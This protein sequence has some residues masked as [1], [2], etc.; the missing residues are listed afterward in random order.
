MHEQTW[1]QWFRMNIDKFLLL[2]AF[3]GIMTFVLHVS[4][5]SMDKELI[6]WGR[7]LGSGAFASFLTM[8]TGSVLRQTGTMP[9]GVLPPGSTVNTKIHTEIPAK[10]DDDSSKSKK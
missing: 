9:P 6:S 4:H 3:I 8:V 10:D 2:T 5:D 1:A 7:E